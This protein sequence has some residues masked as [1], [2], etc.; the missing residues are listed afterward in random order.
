MDIFGPNCMIEIF[1]PKIHNLDFL[2]QIHMFFPENLWFG[3]FW[4]K[5]HGWNNF[6]R[7][8]TIWTILDQIHT[9]FTENPG[10]GHSWTEFTRFHRK[11]MIWTFLDQIVCFRQFL[12]N[13][14]N[15]DFLGSNSYVSHR[16]S[17]I[18][19][20]LNRNSYLTHF[21]RKSTIVTLLDQI[22]MFGTYLPKIHNL[23]IFGPNSHIFHDLDQ[24][25]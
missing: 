23:D 11:P 22:H 25:S 18:R 10:F 12:P 3:H 1:L 7:K 13:I 8:S 14:H 24:N 15:L 4:T 16:E 9:F 17:K 21:Y 19:L 6:Y 2:D 5:I 20:F